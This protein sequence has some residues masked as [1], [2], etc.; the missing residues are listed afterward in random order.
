MVPVRHLLGLSGAALLVAAGVG[1]ATRDDAP[2]APAAPGEVQISEFAFG[3][4]VLTVQAGTT[5]TWRN[6]DGAAHTVDG[7][8]PGGPDSESI[9]GGAQ[10]E[11]AFDE[12]GTYTYF[13]AFHPFMLGTVEVRA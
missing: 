1:I 3:P 2:T 11:H 12:P 8:D 10:F 13:C 9:A 5:V 4:E 7:D 6:A